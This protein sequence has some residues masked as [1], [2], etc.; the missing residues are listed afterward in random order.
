MTLETITISFLILGE[1]ILGKFFIVGRIG[2][3]LVLAAAVY[4]AVEY[5]W[6]FGPQLLKESSND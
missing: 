1:N 4:S 2:L 5:F 6:K 3:W